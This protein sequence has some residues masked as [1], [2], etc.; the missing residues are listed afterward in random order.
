MASAT[1]E[2]YLKALLKLSAEK[3]ECSVSELSG[4]LNVSTPTA[5]SMIKKLSEKEWIKYEK[6]RPIQLTD[7]GKKMAGLVIRKHRL[8][9]MYLVER[10]GFGWE[11]VHEIAEQVEHVKSDA[12]FNRMNEL[13]GD[14]SVDPHGSPIP[15]K[16]GSIKRK[17][18]AKL[19]EG[20]KGQKFRLI[21][22][23]NSS[24]DFLMFLNRREIKLGLVLEILSVESFDG[25]LVVTYDRHKKETLSQSVC[26]KLLVEAV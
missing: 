13:L 25:S 20:N 12:F 26:D 14:P 2:N 16:D 22:L 4:L 21:S 17:K 18:Y 11:E 24:T 15:E 19:S 9:E 23:I 1:E 7:L 10:M 6:Y 3:G 5:N 8:T